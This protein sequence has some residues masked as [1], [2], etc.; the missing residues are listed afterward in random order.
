VAAR[1]L[2]GSLERLSSTG[3]RPLRACHSARMERDTVVGVTLVVGVVAI[4]GAFEVAMYRVGTF[5]VLP[6]ELSRL[7]LNFA[8]GLVLAVALP[9]LSQ[10][11][12]SS[13][14]LL[15]GLLVVASLGYVVLTRGRRARMLQERSP[16]ERAELERR[17]TFLRSRRGVVLFAGMFLSMVV[18]SV[19]ATLLWAAA[20]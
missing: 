7:A 5:S 19:A 17:V 2:P 1:E 10:L 4:A 16:Q 15:I 11:F 6:G 12:P 18:W 9:F 20:R 8:I 3:R 13:F 14:S